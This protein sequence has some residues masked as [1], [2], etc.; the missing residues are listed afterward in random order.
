MF[1][2]SSSCDTHQR[3][4]PSNHGDDL[5]YW[6]DAV[7]RPDP[8]RCYLGLVSDSAHRAV[9]YEREHALTVVARDELCWD[10]DVID[11]RVTGAT[12]HLEDTKGAFA[13]L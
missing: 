7:L 5:L 10:A 2:P 1:F 4:H 13:I 3:T 6:G 9:V 12:S 8:T 11:V